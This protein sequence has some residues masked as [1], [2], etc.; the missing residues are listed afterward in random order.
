MTVCKR[1]KIPQ[2]IVDNGTV[3]SEEHVQQPKQRKAIPVAKLAAAGNFPAGQQ[4]PTSPQDI[5]FAI[6]L[7]AQCMIGDLSNPTYVRMPAS[8]A[9]VLV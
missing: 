4:K 8:C 9:L 2:R 3:D 6:E 1:N 5:E 7:L